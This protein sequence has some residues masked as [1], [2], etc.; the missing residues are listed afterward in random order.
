MSGILFGSKETECI[1]CNNLTWMYNKN[2]DPCCYKC[3]K[4]YNEL[5][6]DINE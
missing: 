3:A 5:E 4:K 6:C 1:H 2:K